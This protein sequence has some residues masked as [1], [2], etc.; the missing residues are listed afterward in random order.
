MVK[1]YVYGSGFPSI[2]PHLDRQDPQDSGGVGPS[3]RPTPP[4]S[5]RTSLAES[6]SPPRQSLDALHDAMSGQGKGKGKAPESPSFQH[7]AQQQL[8]GGTDVGA[9]PTGELPSSPTGS[10]PHAL[11]AT[12][13]Q[14]H[15]PV[16]IGTSPLERL[17]VE[18]H[19]QITSYL[20]GRDVVDLSRASRTLHWRTAAKREAF[21][22][23]VVGPLVQAVARIAA[24]NKVGGA[25]LQRDGFRAGFNPHEAI[26]ALQHALGIPVA[27]PVPAA[28]AALGGDG[29]R[30]LESFIALLPVFGA[31]RNL[32][33]DQQA[34]AIGLA[35]ALFDV[36]AGHL[37]VDGLNRIALTAAR[38]PG[39][40]AANRHSHSLGPELRGAARQ[41]LTGRYFAGDRWEAS[42]VGLIGIP[43]YVGD[44]AFNVPRRAARNMSKQDKN[45]TMAL[46]LLVR[47]LSSILPNQVSNAVVREVTAT[48]AQREP[49]SS[50]KKQVLFDVLI[51]R[52]TPP[53][54][55]LLSEGLDTEHGR[56][57]RDQLWAA[58]VP[59]PNGR[60]ADFE[61]SAAVLASAGNADVVHARALFQSLT[62]RMQQAQGERAA[63][64]ARV[65]T[66]ALSPSTTPYVR[67][68]Y[69]QTLQN[70]VE[71]GDRSDE[72]L[73]WVEALSTDPLADRGQ[74][75]ELCQTLLADP[76]LADTERRRIQSTLNQLNAPPQ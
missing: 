17:P 63:R 13:A 39:D 18:L 64:T 30:A 49:P 12:A 51:P 58:V 65:L 6:G 15:A 40:V 22:T 10:S 35:H 69:V 54:F 73:S 21:K 14:H 47:V 29:A 43:F 76:N 38:L 28:G 4:V 8:G 70:R 57:L 24:A 50:D 26:A 16:G 27:G 5:S 42:V 72:L 11:A 68:M 7:P 31:S 74:A 71:K 45:S 67:R 9:A 48:L 61:C 3:H 19:N 33:R 59:Q 66:E 56:S 23:Q 52:L 53:Q 37:G 1:F 75:C 41:T 55:R 34:S 46:N 60:V 25:R 44:L 20:N 2:R 32:L 36:F 62:R